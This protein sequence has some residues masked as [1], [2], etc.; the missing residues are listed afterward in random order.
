MRKA[1]AIV[2]TLCFLAQAAAATT[3]LPGRDGGAPA[4]AGFKWS[5]T[6]S[7]DADNNGLDDELEYWMAHYDRPNFPVVM[8]YARMP[9]RAETRV[10]GALGGKVDYVS[11]FLPFLTAEVPRGAVRAARA[12]PGVERVEAATPLEFALDTS[13]P[14]IGVDRV[15]KQFGL[16]GEGITICIIDSGIDANHTALDDMDDLN[17]TNDPKVIAFYDASNSPD[18]TDG[19]TKPFDLDGHGTHV[20][21]CAAGTGHGTPD[22]RYIGVAPGAKLVGVKILQNGSS[23]M[24]STDAVRGIEWAMSNKDKYGIRIL[25]MSFGAKFVAPGVTND[26][27]SAMSQ[28]CDQAVADGQVCVAAAGNSGPLK[29]SISPPGDARDVITVGNVRDDHTLNPTSSRGPVGRLTS[30]YIKPDVCGPGTD[31]Y[32]AQANSGDRFLSET[33]TSQACPHISGLAAL[34]LEASPTLRPPDIMSILRSTAEPEKTFPW[35]STPNDDYGWG[36][37]NAFRAVENCTNGTL[38]PVVFINP[39]NNANGTILVTGTASSAR[40]TVVSVEVRIDP[41]AYRMASGTTAWSYSWN[42]TAYADGAHYIT[43]RAF[44][45]TLYSYE[46]RILVQVDNLVVMIV[47]PAGGTIA[48][49]VTFT[50]TAEGLQLVRV[51]ARIDGQSWETAGD[52]TNSS[53]HSW[54]YTINTTKLVNGLHRLEARAFDGEKYSPLTQVEFT[55]YNPVKNPPAPRRVIPGFGEWMAAAAL[56]L[57]LGLAWRRRRGPDIPTSRPSEDII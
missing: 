34:M 16:Q 7:R 49:E 12:L 1:P 45:G 24:S 55:V 35:Q 26:G 23:S 47:P 50:G 13:V 27:N 44:D 28:L 52:P 11:K 21:G 32:S 53:F 19:S 18:V 17:T 41:G 25:S 31:V 14:S 48:G 46:V 22:F 10:L 30:S 38:P 56:A 4:P 39:L 54:L 40:A 33:G 20:S 15:W 29:R 51:E 5:S 6:W 37:V 9:G 57:A 3:L 8:D 43:A 36:T 2:L 42:T